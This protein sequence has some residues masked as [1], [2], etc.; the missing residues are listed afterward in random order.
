MTAASIDPAPPS[1][2]IAVDV[3]V[4]APPSF[5]NA[6]ADRTVTMTIDAHRMIATIAAARRGVTPRR[7]STP[8]PGATVA[9]SVTPTTIGPTTSGTV[10]AAPTRTLTS[11]RPT[12]ERQLHW[13]TRSSHS[14]IPE[15]V[16]ADALCGPP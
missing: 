6:A 12:S 9:A 11:A 14:G 16:V 13:A 15:G 7:T 10:P 5:T 2:G 8:R 1:S 4:A 3:P